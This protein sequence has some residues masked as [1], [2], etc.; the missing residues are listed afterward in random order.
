M[1]IV[2][3]V[4]DNVKEKMLEFYKYKMKDKKPP[5]SVF[6]AIEEDT[7]ITLYESGKVMFQ[8]VSADVDANLWIDMEKHLNNKDIS[9]DEKKAAIDKTYYY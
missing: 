9:I 5:Y 8:G 6:Q 1:N 3:K 7:I 2:F 4:S